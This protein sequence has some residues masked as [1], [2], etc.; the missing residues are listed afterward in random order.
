MEENGL[1]LVTP[2]NIKSPHSTIFTKEILSNG[3]GDFEKVIDQLGEIKEIGD[4]DY[5]N[6]M[7]P[8]M[9]NEELKFLSSLNKFFI[10]QKE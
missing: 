8:M 9:Y 2:T 10:F 7:D 5:T 3:I 1:K 6:R 4:P